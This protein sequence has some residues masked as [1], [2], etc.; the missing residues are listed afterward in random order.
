[1]I[2]SGEEAQGRDFLKTKIGIA[3][4][5]ECRLVKQALEERLNR[6]EL[7][8]NA[9]SDENKLLLRVEQIGLRETQKS[10]WS[11]FLQVKARLEKGEKSVWQTTVLSTASK[12]RSLN[13]FADRP[14]LF[15]AD[16]EEVIQDIARQ[17]VEGPI[18]R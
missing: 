9:E 14:E 2:G 18:R 7:L 15:Q 11:P 1:M 6:I 3:E 8:A 12:I 4:S 16:L 10:F 17:L 13:E 5:R